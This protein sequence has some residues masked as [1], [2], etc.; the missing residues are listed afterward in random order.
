M[1][2]WF[3][4]LPTIRM[5]S[6]FLSLPVSVHHTQ[7]SLSAYTFAQLIVE[8]PVTALWVYHESCLVLPGVRVGQYDN[9]IFF[10]PEV[11]SFKLFHSGRWLR[12]QTHK[13]RGLLNAWQLENGNL[14]INL[15]PS[16]QIISENMGVSIP[17]DML[18]IFSCWL[19]YLILLIQFCFLSLYSEPL[20]P[21]PLFFAI[22]DQG[23]L[24]LM[25][26]FSDLQ[27]VLLR[28]SRVWL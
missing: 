24:C 16:V 17:L 13:F 10:F 22:Y 26:G 21:K 15:E 11:N 14:I 27:P 8:W 7:A 12:E 23:L 1:P 18:I 20:L 19:A 25:N 28:R 4:D 6:T 9:I 2:V 3:H 5:G